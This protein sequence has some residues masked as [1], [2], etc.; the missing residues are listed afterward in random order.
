MKKILLLLLITTALFSQEKL[1]TKDGKTIIL[2]RDY[3]WEYF[4]EE[5]KPESTESTIECDIQQQ[6]DKF[7]KRTILHTKSIIVSDDGSKGIAIHMQRSDKERDIIFSL[8]FVHDKVN[9]IREDDVIEFLFV[10][11]TKFRQKHASKF[12]C[13]GDFRIYLGQFYK[14]LNFLNKLCSTKLEALRLTGSSFYTKEIDP[15]SQEK[16]LNNFNCIKK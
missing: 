4:Y 16:L 15:L 5:K 13:D 11:G 1:K 12:N 8:R 9:C 6:Y 2:H 10:D 14:N 7:N 3:T